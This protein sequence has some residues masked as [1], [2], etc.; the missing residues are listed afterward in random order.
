MKSRL[1]LYADKG[2]V[3]TDGETFCYEI[4]LAIGDDGSD[5]YEITQEEYDK[6]ISIDNELELE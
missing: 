6:K 2:K 5:F 3:L 4:Q 1:I